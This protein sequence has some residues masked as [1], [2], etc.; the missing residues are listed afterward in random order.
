MSQEPQRNPQRNPKKL[1]S[2][3]GGKMIESLLRVK[4]HAM[5]ARSLGWGTAGVSLTMLVQSFI[6]EPNLN[7]YR[8]QGALLLIFCTAM[9]WYNSRAFR[10][11]AEGLERSK[12]GG[13]R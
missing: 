12:L 5:V 4:G 3:D 13:D 9:V 1:V 8:L 10:E 2:L 6:V 7:W 11:L